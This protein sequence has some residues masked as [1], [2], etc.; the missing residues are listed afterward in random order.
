MRIKSEIF[1]FLIIICILF[2]ISTVSASEIPPDITKNNDYQSN[3]ELTQYSNDLNS[4][5]NSECIEDISGIP[6]TNNIESSSENE[7]TFTTLNTDINQSQEELNLTHDYKFNEII[8]K[9]NLTKWGMILIS[10]NKNKFVL[11]G[12]NHVIDGA[13]MGAILYFENSNGEIVINDL[14]FKNIISP[15]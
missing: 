1:V 4:N 14:T 3:M 15:F 6:E 7:S 13:G 5:L 8:D 10:V 12:N 2:S 9:G 11:N